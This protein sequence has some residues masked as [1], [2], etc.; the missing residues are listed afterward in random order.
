MRRCRGWEFGKRKQSLCSV[1]GFRCFFW[2][3]SVITFLPGSPHGWQMSTCPWGWFILQHLVGRRRV[4][5][6]GAGEQSR[7]Q[8]GR[9]VEERNCKQKERR[10]KWGLKRNE[11]SLI[12]RH[13]LYGRQV[14]LF[15]DHVRQT[16]ACSVALTVY[17]DKLLW[18]RKWEGICGWWL[19]RVCL[20]VGQDDGEDEEGEGEVWQADLNKIAL[21]HK[22][23]CR[24]EAR[25]YVPN[26]FHRN[27]R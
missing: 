1:P 4:D 2:A 12:T 3:A 22:A 17:N 24:G 23:L 13:L 5:K 21:V 14:R 25:R 27:K 8:E 16:Q 18:R 7:A 26:S 15:L 11:S 20:Q 10:W 19:P 6:F 9:K